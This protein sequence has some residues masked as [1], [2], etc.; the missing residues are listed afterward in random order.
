MPG[1]YNLKDYLKFYQIPA[2]LKIFY[3]NKMSLS[4]SN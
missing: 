3:S 2:L 4:V 1:Y